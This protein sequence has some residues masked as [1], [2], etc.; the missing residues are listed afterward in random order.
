MRRDVLITALKRVARD[1]KASN[2]TQ[3]FNQASDHVRK[4]EKQDGSFVS[5]EVFQRFSV[6][7]TNYGEAE[8]QVLKILRLEDLLSPIYWQQLLAKADATVIFAMRRAI[9]FALDD[10]PKFIA[11][12]QQEH[13][14]EAKAE[15][16]D[17]PDILR[18]KS[19]LT[20]LVAE[21]ADEFSTP[22]R[23]V[24]ALEAVANLYGVLATIEGTN[25]SE[26]IVLACDSGSDK[27]FDFLGLAKVMEQVRKLILDIWDRRVF[28]R[29]ATV[30]SCMD[31]IAKSLP[32]I[33]KI[34]TLRENGALAPEQAE[35]LKRR[36]IQG[37]TQFLEAG[38]IIDGMADEGSF[39]PRQ[40]MRPEQKLLA[41]PPVVG[42]TEG[43]PGESPSPD[44]NDLT[45][46]EIAELRR[47][48]ATSRSG[49]SS[50]RTRNRKNKGNA[51]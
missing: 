16:Q 43:D 27:S 15:S 36:T 40:L 26:L 14:E 1:L 8:R 38:L 44:P 10:I 2:L 7:A 13:V 47:M 23:L 5:F 9:S 17:L 29:H 35:L 49:P 21:D 41:P 50:N 3:M 12:L 6:A 28:N 45:S 4:G 46:E 33:E 39:S 11:L 18:G 48:A 34:N 37:A 51:P 19:L 24:R 31:L 20:V 30:S 32:I 22:A 25:E 42:A